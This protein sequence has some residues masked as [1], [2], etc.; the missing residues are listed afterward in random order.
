MRA[1]HLTR[2]QSLQLDCR[3]R[4]MMCT[5]SLGREDFKDSGTQTPRSGD[6]A[7]YNQNGGGARLRAKTRERASLATCGFLAR[8]C[9]ATLNTL[10]SDLLPHFV[11]S[12]YNVQTES[13]PLME[14]SRKGEVEMAK[15][16]LEK[17]A[18]PNQENN[19]NHLPLCR[20]SNYLFCI[21]RRNGQH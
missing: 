16:L 17:G 21:Y 11:V 6:L 1:V 13:T 20:P 4:A 5:L 19:V 9:T 3:L 8:Q 18:N 15:L 7:R 2:V 12:S 10:L 14:A